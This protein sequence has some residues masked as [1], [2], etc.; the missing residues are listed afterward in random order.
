MSF[1]NFSFKYNLLK[2]KYL[3][4]RGYSKWDTG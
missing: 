3:E 2:E 1:Q 4:S